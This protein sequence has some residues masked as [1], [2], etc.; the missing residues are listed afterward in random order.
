MSETLEIENVDKF[1]STLDKTSLEDSNIDKVSEKLDELL[2]RLR[3]GG[4]TIVGSAEDDLA[5]LGVTIEDV[6][7]VKI[8]ERKALAQKKALEKEL[9]K[10]GLLEDTFTVLETTVDAVV[11]KTARLAAHIPKLTSLEPSRLSNQSSENPVR[12][13]DMIDREV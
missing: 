2:N 6:S 11:A 8:E 1:F 4:P 7:P 3:P 5:K 10:L 12:T 9:D 13:A